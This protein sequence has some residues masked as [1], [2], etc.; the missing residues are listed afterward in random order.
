M[1]MNTRW[2]VHNGFGIAFTCDDLLVPNNAVSGT[3]LVF[4]LA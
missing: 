2:P 3:D 1:S 4:A